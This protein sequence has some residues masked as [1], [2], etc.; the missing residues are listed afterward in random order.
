MRRLLPLVI[1]GS[2]LFTAAGSA[3]QAPSAGPYAVIKT[4]KTGGSGGFDYIYADV[5]GRRLY[6]PR[7]GS[8]ARCRRPT[9]PRPSPPF[10]VV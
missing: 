7:G 8:C 10:P 1:L 2:I 6:I 5:V 9:P 3:R 4:A